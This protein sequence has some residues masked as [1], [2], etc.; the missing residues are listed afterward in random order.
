[1]AALREGI[2]IIFGWVLW[3]LGVLMALSRPAR[4]AGAGLFFSRTEQV[5]GRWVIDLS[6]SR[7]PFRGTG[8]LSRGVLRHAVEPPLGHCAPLTRASAA[9]GNLALAPPG[10]SA[11]LRHAV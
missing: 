10:D 8:N 11:G 4:S 1:M 5:A 3:I 7:G 6:P 2:M 9:E